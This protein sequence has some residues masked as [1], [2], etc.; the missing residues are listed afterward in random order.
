ML[1]F[2]QFPERKN[3]L[4]R[5]SEPTSCMH[6]GCSN[7][8]FSID[9]NQI[10]TKECHGQKFNLAR[11]R[12]TVPLEDL[13]WAWPT[14]AGIRT[15]SQWCMTL[16]PSVQSDFICAARLQLSVLVVRIDFSAPSG[17]RIGRISPPRFLAEYY[18][19]RL[20]IFQGNFR[21]ILFVVCLFC[22]LFWFLSIK[23]LELFISSK[24]FQP[25]HLHQLFNYDALFTF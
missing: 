9:G 20:P 15:H 5:N 10:R 2:S 6:I 17:S 23:Y 7:W 14:R 25:I 24:Y 21:C 11:Q 18:K 3:S 16:P 12:E 4:S 13:R 19:R 22:A 1:V 8:C